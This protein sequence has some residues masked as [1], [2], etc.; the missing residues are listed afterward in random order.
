MT[1][2]IVESWA[3]SGSGSK[4]RKLT[5]YSNAPFVRLSVN[6]VTVDGPTAMPLFSRVYFNT[7]T[8]VAGNVTVEA[9][10]S[11]TGPVLASHTR[12]SWGAPAA[13]VLSLDA[14]SVTTGTGSAVYLDGTDVALLRATV[15]D[16]AGV[17]VSDSS[18]N[19]TF[20]VSSGP[21]L[22]LG[23]CIIKLN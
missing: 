15:V 16:A 3:P 18:V 20:T 13:I 17:H 6:G 11:A 19:I 9:L 5:V 14:P 4:T 8:Y 10:G 12:F 23:E 1:A 7:V 22:V 21:G 2:H